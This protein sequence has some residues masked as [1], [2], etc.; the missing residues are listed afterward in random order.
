M[1]NDKKHDP[2]DELLRARLRIPIGADLRLKTLCQLMK[3]V[4]LISR[5]VTGQAFFALNET[6][7]ILLELG[8]RTGHDLVRAVLAMNGGTVVKAH[9]LE[10]IPAN[11]SVIIGST[12]PIGTFDFLAHAGALLDHRSDLKVVAGR[13]AERFLGRDLIVPV[14]L[15]RQDKVLTARQT[16]A[17]M[18]AHLKEEGALLVFGSGRVPA[19]RDGRLVEPPWRTGV[20]RVS[21]ESGAPIVPASANMRNSRHYYRTRRLAALLSGGNDEVGRRVASL[22]YVSELI[23]KLGGTYDVHYGPIQPAGTAPDLLKELA[24]GLVPGLYKS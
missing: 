17:G 21:A 4:D 9:G 20:T 23:A 7:Q 10:N 24:E 15:D 16:R 3:G 13:E 5:T 12:H 22:R 11:G 1:T 8:E 14:D 2:L 18:L 19:L 6:E